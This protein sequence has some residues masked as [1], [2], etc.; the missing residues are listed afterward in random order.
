MTPEA[1]Q[2]IASRSNARILPYDERNWDAETGDIMVDWNGRAW[3]LTASN[4]RNKRA[5]GEL[6]P[7]EIK[8]PG[9]I[10]VIIEEKLFW[11]LSK[12]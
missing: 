7:I 3:R 6:T 1:E 10:A 12:L 5:A 9:Y 8:K 4:G 11:K 2:L